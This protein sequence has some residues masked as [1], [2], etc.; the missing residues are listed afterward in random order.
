VIG[1]VGLL[2][3]I[4]KRMTAH[5]KNEGDIIILLGRTKEDLGGTEYMKMVH[6]QERGFPPEI[7]LDAELALHGL[8]L[9][10]IGR[11]L[12]QSAHD[13]SEGGLAVAVAESAIASPTCGSVDPKTGPPKGAEIHLKESGIRPDALLFG[14]SQSRILVSAFP[15]KLPEIEKMAKQAQVPFEKIGVV[16]GDRLV[17]HPYISLPVSELASAWKGSLPEQVGKY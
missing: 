8:C 14:E 1:A 16:T 4:E 3:N 2:E 11:G 15:E 6:H 5:F 17:I 12:V 7:N 10:L 13:L 9:D